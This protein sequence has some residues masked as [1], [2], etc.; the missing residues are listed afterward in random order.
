MKH[1]KYIAASVFL[2]LY[3]VLNILFCI[4]RGPGSIPGT[5]FLSIQNSDQLSFSG[6]ADLAAQNGCLLYAETNQIITDPEQPLAYQK[7]VY[8]IYAAEKDQPAVLKRHLGLKPGAIRD[9]DGALCELTVCDIAELDANDE[10]RQL[11]D[12]VILI[13]KHDRCTGC[14]RRL[15]NAYP[16]VFD[17]IL[18]VKWGLHYAFPC[19]LLA[20]IFILLLLG[21]YLESAFAKKEIAIRVLHGD[22]AARYYISICLRDTVVFS[23]LFL[24]C[25]IAQCMYTQ[26]TK[27]FRISFWLLLP[28]TA[29]IWLVNLQLL[30]IQ[31]KEMLY[32]HQ[33]SKG[34][35]RAFSAL[36]HIAAV[37]SCILILYA[38]NMIGNVQKYDFAESFIQANRD[39]TYVEMKEPQDAAAP[40]Q[41]DQI[42]E[43]K[44]LLGEIL[45]EERQFLKETDSVLNPVTIADLSFSMKD[46]GMH[47]I[48]DA[49]YCNHRAVPYLQTVI[50]EVAGIDLE[51]YDAGLLLP[52]TFPLLE[53]KKAEA[54]LMGQF[55]TYEGYR[56]AQSRIQ[57]CFYKPQAPLLSFNFSYRAFTYH[58]LSAICIASDT[59]SR[60]DADSLQINH[61]MLTECSIFQDPE[62]LDPETIARS[63]RFKPIFHHVYDRFYKEYRTRKTLLLMA[64]LVSVMMFVFYISVMYTILKLDYQVNATELAIRKTLGESMLQKNKR[65]F[66]SAAAVGGLNLCIAA[67]AVKM[68]HLSAAA[69]L[70]PV[71]LYLLNNVL[72]CVMI[73]RVERQK[74]TKILKGG[75]L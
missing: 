51:Q 72:V 37:F 49:L 63:Y 64:C 73:R 18:E 71:M 23:V 43:R 4:S 16:G 17:L 39:Y 47:A 41:P 25:I 30:R 21:C 70:I 31:P 24:I 55:E 35:L 74:I 58:D 65:H 11:V 10:L 1:S 59:Y 6:A 52:E 38:A 67:I 8:T 33:L 20:F 26:I 57:T 50:P 3:S 14:I 13:G 40:V 27:P 5:T 12:S 53:Q 56:P 61:Y 34:I 32:G 28:F 75:A 29:G 7:T 2:I 66:I 22:A 44:E 69:V 15:K 48:W 42:R 9:T 19:I 36:G 45:D 46:S 54:F 60:T 68:L 62:V